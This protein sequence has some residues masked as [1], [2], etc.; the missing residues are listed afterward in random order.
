MTKYAF[1]NNHELSVA[2]KER[3]DKLREVFPNFFKANNPEPIYL[4]ALPHNFHSVKTGSSTGRLRSQQRPNAPVNITLRAQYVD[5]ATGKVNLISVSQQPPQVNPLTGIAN[6]GK[7][8]YFGIGH[9][10]MITDPNVLYFLYYHASSV[11]Q[12]GYDFGNSALF[13]FAMPEK[14]TAEKLRVETEKAEFVVMLSKISDEAVVEILSKY[15]I[16][17]MATSEMNRTA[18]IGKFSSAS[19]EVKGNLRIFVET[20]INE[21]GKKETQ[22]SSTIQSVVEKAIADGKLKFEGGKMYLLKA[23]SQE[24]SDRAALTFTNEDADAQL[25]EAVDYFSKNQGKLDNIK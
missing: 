17:P 11:I 22:S 1:Y 24:F 23:G 5:E 9:Q 12:N 21:G 14:E 3:M 25:L 15:K 13:E 16:T 8:C 7:H 6:Y 2:P 20:I 10:V 4:R 18:L 19:S